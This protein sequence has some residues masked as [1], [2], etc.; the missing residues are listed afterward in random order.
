MIKMR[1]KFGVVDAILWGHCYLAQDNITNKKKFVQKDAKVE[2]NEIIMK[3][4]LL[5]CRTE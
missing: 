3:Y 5:F 4:S 1:Y 2:V